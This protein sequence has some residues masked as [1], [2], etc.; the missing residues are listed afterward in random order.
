MRYKRYGAV[1]DI[2]K[3]YTPS[4]ILLEVFSQFLVKVFPQHGEHQS[5]HTVSNDSCLQTTAK[6]AHVTVF[7]YHSSDSV[8]VA[9]SFRTRLTIRLDYSK[10]IGNAI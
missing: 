9:N 5:L 8:W 2:D 6:Q 7:L 3:H 10:R 4:K 1:I